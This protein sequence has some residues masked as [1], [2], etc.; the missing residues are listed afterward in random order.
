VRLVGGPSPGQG[1]VEVYH[2]GVWGTVCDDMFTYTAATVVCRSLG[3][4][5]VRSLCLEI[6]VC[7]RQK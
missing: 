2:N 3:Y 5:Y 4:T 7:A 1:R 6:C